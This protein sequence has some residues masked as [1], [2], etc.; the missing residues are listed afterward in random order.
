MAEL[1]LINAPANGRAE[2]ESGSPASGGV[3]LARAPIAVPAAIGLPGWRL[4]RG[5]R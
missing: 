4:R 2:D 5:A 3:A 1:I